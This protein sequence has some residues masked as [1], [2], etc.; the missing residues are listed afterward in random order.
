MRA[1]LH[2]IWHLDYDTDSLLLL[3]IKY[4]MEAH[5]EGF[6]RELL[7]DLRLTLLDFSDEVVVR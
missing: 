5:G 4:V 3:Q 1:C 6:R 7:E 2:G